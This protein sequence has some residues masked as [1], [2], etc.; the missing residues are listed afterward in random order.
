MKALF[1][2]DW[3][4]GLYCTVQS[5]SVVPIKLRIITFHLDLCKA[6]HSENQLFSY[7][8]SFS[9][10]IRAKLAIVQSTTLN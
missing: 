8:N 9:F 6:A 4:L 1:D 10:M 5:I 3:K 2:T 7:F